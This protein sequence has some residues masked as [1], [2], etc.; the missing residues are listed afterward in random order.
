MVT[1]TLPPE[2]EKAVTENARLRGTTP[3]L[4]TLDVLEERFLRSSETTL[5]PEEE[6]L[7]DALKDYIGAVNS[8]EK[9]PEGSTLSEN[10]G[11]RFR[12]LMRGGTYSLPSP[13]EAYGAAA[14]LSAFLKQEKEAQ[15]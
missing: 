1:I 4:L 13:H 12:E 7:A 6:T 10:T 15:A 11:K 14:Q 5:L 8:S 3:E 2:L 9:Y